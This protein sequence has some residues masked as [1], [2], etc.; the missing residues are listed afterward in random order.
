MMENSADTT[1]CLQTP[2]GRGGI[3]VIGLAGPDSRRILAAMFHPARG[4]EGEWPIGRLLLGRLTDGREVIDEAIVACTPHAAE[5]NIHGGPVVARRALRRLAQLGATVVDPESQAPFDPAHPRWRNPAVGREMLHA[6]LRAPEGLIVAA[7]AQQWSAGIS[8]LAREGI[9]FCGKTRDENN[10][11]EP[12]AQASGLSSAPLRSRLVRASHDATPETISSDSACARENSLP[13]RFLA[14]AGGLAAMERLLTPAE[15]VLAGPPNV[16]K[17]T[18]ANAL[19]GRPVS[20][21]HDRPG[22]TRDWVRELAIFRGIA[23]YLTDT[24]GLWRTEGEVDAESVRR[25]W[26]RIASA[27]VI[28]LLSAERGEDAQPV[29]HRL[30]T[31]T[32]DRAPA[33]LR[34]ASKIDSCPPTGPHDL[35]VSARTGQGLDDLRQAVLKALDLADFDPQQPRAF[36]QRQAERLRAAAEAWTSGRADRAKTHL[37]E[38]LEGDVPPAGPGSESSGKDSLSRLPGGG[39]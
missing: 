20:I 36:T 19:V 8:R 37:L 4:Q 3:A 38:L 15:V 13:Q 31:S 28:L 23:V 1:A 26:E 6:L 35:A 25:A 12:R 34:V 21:V 24:A 2:P 29:F 30:Q 14:A 18:L 5:I 9:G 7:L 11:N 17:S 32:K 10:S 27:D 39:V 22:T 33:I 16:G